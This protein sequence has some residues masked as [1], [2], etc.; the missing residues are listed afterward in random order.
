MVPSQQILAVRRSEQEHSKGNARVGSR[1]FIV[2]RTFLL[3]SAMQRSAATKI[4]L[5]VGT[6]NVHEAICR[7]RHDVGLL[8]VNASEKRREA[9]ENFTLVAKSQ[10]G[11]WTCP[12]VL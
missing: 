6:A 10:S 7:A 8:E 12:R 5:S 9:V 3:A 4:D 1:H 11:C 2:L